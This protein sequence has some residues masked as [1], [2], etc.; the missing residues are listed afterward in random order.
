MGMLTTFIVALFSTSEPKIAEI[1]H[2][3]EYGGWITLLLAADTQ[4][5]P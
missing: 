2:M 5:K 4:A 3:T 1:R